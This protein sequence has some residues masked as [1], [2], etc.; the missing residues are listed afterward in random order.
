V[1][2]NLIE[3]SYGKDHLR[4]DAGITQEMQTAKLENNDLI[5]K[6]EKV[7]AAYE[8]HIRPMFEAIY[9]RLRD[10]LAAGRQDS[11]VFRHHVYFVNNNRR[12]YVDVDAP[13]YD[14]RNEDPDRIVTDYIASMTDDYFVDLYHYLFPDGK[15]G[16]RYVSYFD[17]DR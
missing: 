5:Y 15:H 11:W 13:A 9:S 1:T 17:D 16:V 7:T 4:L 3:N 14:Y 8:E 12:Y 6:H 2:V 10:D